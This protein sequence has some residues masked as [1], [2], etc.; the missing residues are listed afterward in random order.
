MT[1]PF[2]DGLQDT[3]RSTVWPG[4]VLTRKERHLL[5]EAPELLDSLGSS[6]HGGGMGR[7]Q[8]VTNMYVDRTYDCSDPVRD[9]E[10]WLTAWGYPLETTA[11]LLT[12]VQLRHAA[13]HEEKNEQATVFCCTTAGVSNA[14][15]AGSERRTFPAYTPGTINIMLAID[16]QLTK[17]AMLNAVMTAVEAK[18]AALAD[19]DVRDPDNGLIA[20]GTTTDAVV[21]GVSQSAAYAGLHRYAGTATDLGAM[22]GRAV[23]ITVKEGL[24]AAWS[25][26]K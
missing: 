24:L 23:Y 1:T 17:A 14:A 21:L 3:Y 26:R 6:I 19:L 5:L 11:G 15:R 22:I 25:E 13:V 20:T 9:T 12:A 10:E 8:R 16:G 7:L 4:L 2:M 18:T